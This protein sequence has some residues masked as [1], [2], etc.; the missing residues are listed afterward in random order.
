MKK[1][2]FIIL[3]ILIVCITVL[4][5]FQLYSDYKK[6]IV[7]DNNVSKNNNF[8]KEHEQ[9]IDEKIQEDIKGMSLSEKIGQMIVISYRTLEYTEELNNILNIV[10]PGGFILF[11]ENISTYDETT[12]YISKLKSMADIPL[13]IGID[14]EGGRVQRI[15]KLSDANVLEIPSMY[16]LGK[17]GNK[18][19]SKSVGKVLASEI[20][21]FGINLDYAPSLDIF[22][23]PNNTVIGDRAFGSD[24]QTVIDMALPFAKGM[25]EENIIPV[26]KHF[27]GHGDTDADSHVE[28]PVVNKTKEELYE[29]EFLTFKAAIE[30]GAQ[31]IMVA[32]IALPNITGDYIPSTL[33]REVV[34]GILREELGFGGV[35]TTDAVN[36]SA[37]ADNYSLD[38]ICKYSIN[39]GIDMILMPEDPIE[40]VNIIEKLVE[41]GDI[42]EERINESVERILKLKYNNN[43]FDEVELNKD[44]I[45]TQEHIDI[46]NKI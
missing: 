9:T 30:D 20:A 21:T 15:K 11:S 41:N 4:L 16:S 18:E 43:L 45:G 12:K 37:L 26:Y 6:S 17:T 40:A 36:M 19:L 42:T 3:I 13:L 1:M 24:Y 34:T 33:S 2:F 46:I 32:H 7:S 23:N 8:V 38:E 44:N 5:F 14:Q 29:N 10:K 27:P 25:E 39:A 28:L 35:V 31:V 22:S